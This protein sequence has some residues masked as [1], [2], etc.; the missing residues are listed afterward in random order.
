MKL[1]TSWITNS[2][3]DSSSLQ[4]LSN[5][6]QQRLN[7]TDRTNSD[8][9]RKANTDGFLGVVTTEISSMSSSAPP[10]Q[11]QQQQPDQMLQH[12]QQQFS[13]VQQQ[14][15]QHP[16]QQL[17]PYQYYAAPQPYY[18]QQFPSQYHQYSYPHY[19]PTSRPQPYPQSRPAPAPQSQAPPQLQ[20][21]PQE[22]QT[23]QTQNRSQQQGETSNV[24]SEAPTPHD[25]LRRHHSPSDSATEQPSNKRPRITALTDTQFKQLTLNDPMVTTSDTR[26]QDTD[27]TVDDDPPSLNAI[28]GPTKTLIP[29]HSVK[30]CIDIFDIKSQTGTA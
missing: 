16:P 18:Y 19:I 30:S 28:P 21:Q 2:S 10:S 24:R 5:T 1:P 20:R 25:Q 11:Q 17:Q 4:P 8:H 29:T 14:A 26:E 6:S 9:N 13:Q 12:S 22:S 15:Q 7:L 23:R 27:S 3:A